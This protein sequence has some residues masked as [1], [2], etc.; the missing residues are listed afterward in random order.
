ML[1]KRINDLCEH[2]LGDRVLSQATT[3]VHAR[4][5]QSDHAYRLGGEEFAILLREDRIE[6][7][8]ILADRIRQTIE[9]ARFK[10]DD[11]KAGVTVSFGIA[12]FRNS[13]T[14][15]EDSLKR[16]DEALYNSKSNAR[17]TVS[18]LE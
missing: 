3:L 17:N 5:R 1:F 4:L 2:A 9:A 11:A 16:A 18:I 6:N 10:L 8:W 15:H 7:A 12:K 13:D 14:N